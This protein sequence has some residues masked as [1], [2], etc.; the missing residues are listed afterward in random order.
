M[1]FELGHHMVIN[2]LKEHFESFY[3]GYQMMEAVCLG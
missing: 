2:V 1:W 3:T